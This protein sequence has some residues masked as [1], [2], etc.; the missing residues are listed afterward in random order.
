VKLDPKLKKQLDD[1]KGTSRDVEAVLVM[2]QSMSVF[3]DSDAD[4]V[5]KLAEQVVKRVKTDSGVSPS[6]VNVLGNI[7]AVVVSAEEPF[8]RGLLAQPEF[9]S[10]AANSSDEAGSAAAT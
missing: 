3:S 5:T 4:R 1:A 2:D 10:A 6:V 7:G 9:E 8:V